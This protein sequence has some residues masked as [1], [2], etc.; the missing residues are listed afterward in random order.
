MAH[1]NNRIEDIA[2][3]TTQLYTLINAALSRDA[4]REQYSAQSQSMRETGIASTTL[5]DPKLKFGIGGMPVDSFRFDEDPMTNISVGL[6]QEFGRG[7]TLELQQK[8]A[9]QQADG[10]ALKVTA[11]E[12]EVANT[13]TKLWLEL[14]YL[15]QANRVLLENQNLLREMEH[16]IKTNYSIGQSDAQDLLNAQLQVSRFDEKLHTNTQMQQRILAQL[17][18][19]LGPQWLRQNSDVAA[20][21]ELD[22]A[23]LNQSLSSNSHAE[24][25]PLLMS[26]PMVKMADAQIHTNQT[27]VA[28]AEEAYSPKFGVEVMYGY[29]QANGMGGEPAS[30]LVSAYLTM[31]IPLFTED[32]QDRS[33]AAAQYQVVAAKSNRDVLL[34]QMNAKVNT[35][36]VDKNNLEQRLERYQSTLLNHARSRTKAVERG[37]QNNTSQFNDVINA[38]RDELALELEQ[39]RLIADINI[40]NSDL[41]YLLGGFDYAVEQPQLQPLANHANHANQQKIL[42]SH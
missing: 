2:A 7:A 4:S 21:L 13:M 27:Q 8:K 19:W 12:L 34:A 37:Y 33:H 39:W 6:M 18:E 14:G 10:I 25:Y 24:Y 32:R 16:F 22:W 3:S 15:Q 29:R 31:D 38:A 9:N 28:I 42:G 40:T 5:M 30:D 11:R 41:A 35:L 20:T 23:L 1:E 17:S 36:L 26:H